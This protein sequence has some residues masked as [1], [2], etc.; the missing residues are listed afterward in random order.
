MIAKDFR[1]NE[2]DAAVQSALGDDSQRLPAK[3]IDDREHTELAPVM[4]MVLDL[5]PLGPE[6]MRRVL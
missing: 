4:G 3:F 1:L 5:L 6:V 2:N